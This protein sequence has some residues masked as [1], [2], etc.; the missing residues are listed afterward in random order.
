MPY[1]NYNT[2][3]TT[4]LQTL[5]TY[6]TL[7]GDRFRA[8]AYRTAIYNIQKYNTKIKN[9]DDIRKIDGIGKSICDKILEIITTKK[10]KLLDDIIRKHP[11]LIIKK[12]IMDIKG[13][14]PL[15]AKKIVDKH[16]I[17]SMTDFKKKVKSGTI[18]LSVGQKLALKYYSDMNKKI[19]RKEVSASAR[20]IKRVATQISNDVN[21][22]IA[23]SYVTTKKM[24]GDIDI[25][26]TIPLFKKYHKTFNQIITSLKE[27]KLLIG[28]FAKGGTYYSGL[29]KLPKPKSIVRKI[30][31]HMVPYESLPLHTLYFSGS[32]QFSR[33]IR[34][35]AKKKGYKL[36]Q[37]E[38]VRLRDG[39]K[40]MVNK[41]IDVFN[42]LDIDYIKPSNR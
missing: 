6:Y 36:N 40:M 26:I 20:L 27:K 21:I 31:I 42:I 13:I 1:K 2:N 12:K 35:E 19:S 38:L 14:G 15:L 3:I 9:M 11:D 5:Q 22:I 25:I 32:A 4:I 23:G 39:K 29:F 28:D 16:K 30:D 10:L 41:E 34:A 18:K 17:I 8:N 7:L 37:K 33:Y 24:M